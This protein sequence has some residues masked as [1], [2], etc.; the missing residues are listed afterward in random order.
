[1]ALTDGQLAI[2]VGM[3]VQ[4]VVFAYMFGGFKGRTE[5]AL[6]NHDDRLD[7]LEKARPL[8]AHH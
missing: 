5:T 2:L 4:T 8:S 3:V 6:E 1:V 7:R